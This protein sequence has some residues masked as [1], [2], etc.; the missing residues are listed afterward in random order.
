MKAVFLLPLAAA[1][2]FAACTPVVDNRQW[3]A[4]RNIV[5]LEG[6]YARGL[7]GPG[8][9]DCIVTNASYVDLSAIIAASTRSAL[10]RAV[11]P[12]ISGAGYGACLDRLYAGP[13]PGEAA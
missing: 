5:A 9:L 6:E 10:D 8:I 3:E 4:K 11:A 13:A 7:A 1:A 12:V 2:I